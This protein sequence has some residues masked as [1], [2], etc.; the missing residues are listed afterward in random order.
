MPLFEYKCNRCGV[1]EALRS[2]EPKQLLPHSCGGTL[3]RVYSKFNF[4]VK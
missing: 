3:L 4:V 2:S 1:I